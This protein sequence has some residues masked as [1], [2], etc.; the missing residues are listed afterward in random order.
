M[1][2]E[3]IVTADGRDRTVV[4]RRP[5]SRRAVPGHDRRQRRAR[6]MRRAIRPGHVVADASTARAS[7]STSTS[8]APGSRRRSARARRCSRSRTRCTAGSPPPRSPRGAARGETIRAPIAGKV[9][10][11][12]V[13]VGDTVAPGTAVIVLEAMKMENELV[14]ERGG[15]VSAVAQAGRSGRRY[16]RPARRADLSLRQPRTPGSAKCPRRVAATVAS[17]PGHRTSHATG[18]RRCRHLTV[19]GI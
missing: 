3:L 15:T 5:A 18:A 17:C 11:V 13:A 4:G 7:S 14:A 8:G 16:R 19:T 2:R 12:L 10:K 1:K 6:S 9:V